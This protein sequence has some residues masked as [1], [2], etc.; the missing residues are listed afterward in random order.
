M[1][2]PGGD[3]RCLGGRT[4]ER[5]HHARRCTAFVAATLHFGDTVNASVQICVKE[6]LESID[7]GSFRCKG[8]AFLP[9][10]TYACQ[11]HGFKVVEHLIVFAQRVN[12][13]SKLSPSI[14]IEA[15]W[16]LLPLRFMKR[17]LP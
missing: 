13:E 4:S 8:F 17:N 11:Q 16:K 12:G 15:M 14:V 7:I 6:V 2:F 1:R 10:E 9:E 3:R 5:P